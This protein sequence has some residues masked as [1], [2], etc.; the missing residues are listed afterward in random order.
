MHSVRSAAAAQ[1]TQRYDRHVRGLARALGSPVAV[2][3]AVVVLYGAWILVARANGHDMRDFAFVGQRFVDR[4]SVSPAIDAYKPLATTRD[5][6]D[7]QFFLYIALDPARAHAYIDNPSYRY[8]R[9]F[10]PLAARALAAT[11]E[12]WV[13][14]ALVVVNI[15]AIALGSFA[16]AVWLRRGGMSQWL[17]LLFALYPGVFVAVLRDLSE[18][19]AYS[20]VALAVATFDARRRTRLVASAALFALAIL[21]RETTALF[22]ALWALA[23]LLDGATP[24]AA[25][26][27]A[28]AFAAGAVAPYLVYKV[29]VLPAWLGNAGFPTQ[30]LPTAV[31][32]AGIADYWPWDANAIQQLYSVVLPGSLC[33]AL[34]AWA[35]WRGAREPAVAALML[36][37]LLWVVLLPRPAFQ[38][39]YASLRISTG[40][41]LAMVLAAPALRLRLGTHGAWLWIPAV[42]WF[43]PW[44]FLLPV[45][46]SRAS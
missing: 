13:P 21:T 27:R 3:A 33:L 42:A 11:V 26:R 30:V 38:D 35:F 10:Y 28:A 40:V 1:R 18:G 19:V 5:G 17:A 2:A 23:L 24:A 32:F 7:G 45:A 41:V 44:W 9:I 39:P 15:L 12:D 29:V 16:L 43:A 34:A 8:G 6:Y 20:L 25:W 4:S 36:N 46:F 14:A 37:A 22:A 31:P